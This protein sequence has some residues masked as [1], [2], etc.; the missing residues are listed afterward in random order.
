MTAKKLTPDELAN[1]VKQMIAD[2][3]DALD[4]LSFRTRDGDHS[5]ETIVAQHMNGKMTAVFTK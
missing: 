2:N 5:Y 3:G 1:A 4:R